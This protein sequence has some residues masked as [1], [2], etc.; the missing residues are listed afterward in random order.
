[1]QM[2]SVIASTEPKAQ[3]EPQF[4]WSR[5]CQ[6]PFASA[7][8]LLC[9]SFL[10]MTCLLIRDNKVLPKKD[11]QRSLQVSKGSFRTRRPLSDILHIVS[12]SGRTGAAQSVPKR[13]LRFLEPIFHVPFSIFERVATGPAPNYRFFSMV[14]IPNMILTWF[15][16][17]LG[18]ASC[19]FAGSRAQIENGFCPFPR[20]ITHV[21]ASFLLRTAVKLTKGLQIMDCA[22]SKAHDDVRCYE[23]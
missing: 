16:H 15:L 20:T 17:S 1:M 2:R 8:K 4:A 11:L 10:G 3:Q 22:E 21:L 14:Q 12:Q 23:D 19:F 7:W 9:S 6:A 13:Q 5:T 18:T